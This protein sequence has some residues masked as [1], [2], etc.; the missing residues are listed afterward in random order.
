MS[1]DRICAVCGQRSDQETCPRCG[2]RSPEPVE[3]SEASVADVPV[4][5]E[6]DY[7]K[8][9]VFLNAESDGG[10]TG[11]RKF[12]GTTIGLTFIYG[13]PIM[14]VAL[15]YAGRFRVLFVIGAILGVQGA[16][17]QYRG[18]RFASEP[19]INNEEV[20]ARISPPLKELCAAAHVAVPQV[21]VKR[22]VWPAAVARMNNRPT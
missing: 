10:P 6:F 2:T 7:E 8:D 1:S 22:S 17:V 16:Y 18:K 20:R 4:E 15:A 21:R 14:C 11:R 13:I 12:M 9:V 19:V 3:G 5:D